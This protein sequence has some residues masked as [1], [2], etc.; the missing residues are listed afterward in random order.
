MAQPLFF[1]LHP[2]TWGA[3][4]SARTPTRRL[5]DDLF[6]VHVERPRWLEPPTPERSSDFRLRQIP[7]RELTIAE[8]TKERTVVQAQLA[9]AMPD[10]GFRP[11]ATGASADSI[12]FEHALSLVAQRELPIIV[13]E[14]VEGRSFWFFPRLKPLG[15]CGVFVAKRAG[16]MTD[17]GA[18]F[19]QEDWLWAYERGLIVDTPV[20]L[21]ITRVMNLAGTRRFLRDTLRL[22]LSLESYQMLDRPPITLTRAVNWTAIQALRVHAAR[23][24][25]W[26]I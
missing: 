17:A 4:A 8:R 13:N 9:Q 18:K 26:R 23:L 21:V 14:I 19:P 16:A 3:L 6:E 15:S 10:V 12:S 2:L 20:D 1:E 24:F 22:A 5:R 11:G 25:E 7:A